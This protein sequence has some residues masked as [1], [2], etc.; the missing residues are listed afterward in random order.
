MFINWAEHCVNLIGELENNVP[1][2]LKWIY[3]KHCTAAK[4]EL[5]IRRIRSFMRNRTGIMSGHPTAA[6]LEEK[7]KEIKDELRRDFSDEYPQKS[8]EEWILRL[9]QPYDAMFAG[10]RI[11]KDRSADDP[12]DQE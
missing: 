9:F 8:L 3:Q 7:I 5:I 6:V 11:M 4:A 10:L 2:D 1:D 12:Q